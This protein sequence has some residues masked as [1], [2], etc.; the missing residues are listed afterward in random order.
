MMDYV[1]PLYEFRDKIFHVHFKDVKLY[2]EKLD[3]N[4]IMAY[5]LD[6]MAPKLPGLGDIDWGVFVSAL[7]D[8]RYDGYACIEIEDKAFEENAQRVLDSILL[9]KKY[10]EQYV[11]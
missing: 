3:A 11:I 1:K 10:M 8:I 9:S 2:R 7:T 5:P 6:Y 4:G